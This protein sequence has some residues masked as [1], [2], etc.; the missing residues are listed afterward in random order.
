MVQE[1]I[2]FLVFLTLKEVFILVIN[3]N[4]IRNFNFLKFIEDYGLWMAMMEVITMF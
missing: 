2:S 1:S 3:I 4:I